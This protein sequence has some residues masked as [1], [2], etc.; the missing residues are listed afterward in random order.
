MNKKFSKESI[1]ALDKA[2]KEVMTIPVEGRTWRRLKEAY[3]FLTEMD[4]SYMKSDNFFYY[5]SAFILHSRTVLWVMKKEYSKVDGFKEWYDSKEATKGEKE[6]LGKLTKLRND[7][8]KKGIIGTHIKGTLTVSEENIRELEHFSNLEELSNYFEAHSGKAFVILT[9][10]E[11]KAL[12]RKKGLIRGKMEDMV[13]EF[14]DF[15]DRDIMEVCKHYFF[16]L[17][18]IVFECLLK[19]DVPKGADL[20]EQRQ[21]KVEGFI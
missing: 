21:D 19:F 6:L 3:F 17:V 20:T 18:K 16:F 10:E 5:L 11:L 7:A 4:R 13:I 8:E 2:I 14:E 12:G 15:P 1:E 9:E